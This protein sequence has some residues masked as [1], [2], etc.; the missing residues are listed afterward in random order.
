MRFC[1]Q[2]PKTA[3]HFRALL[4]AKFSET[5][6]GRVRFLSLQRD[7]DQLMKKITLPATS[8]RHWRNF[9]SF[10]GLQARFMLTYIDL[11]LNHKR[12]N[13][14]L[15]KQPRLYLPMLDGK[16]VYYPP[17]QGVPEHEFRNLVETSGLNAK[18]V[19]PCATY[20]NPDHVWHEVQSWSQHFVVARFDRELSEKGKAGRIRAALSGIVDAGRKGKFLEVRDGATSS[21][22]C[23]A[24]VA[25]QRETCKGLF[26]LNRGCGWGHTS[27][28]ESTWVHLKN[29]SPSTLRFRWW[30]INDRILEVN[31]SRN[32]PLLLSSKA[33]TYGVKKNGLQQRF[34]KENRSLTNQQL[35]LYHN[36]GEI[37]ADLCV[38]NVSVPELRWD[39]DSYV[40]RPICE[41]GLGAKFADE[42]GP[43]SWSGQEVKIL[44]TAIEEHAANPTIQGRYGDRNKWLAY[45][46]LG[47]SPKEVRAAVKFIDF[48]IRKNPL[49]IQRLLSMDDEES[50]KL[51]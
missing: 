45:E 19:V 33:V 31:L 30:L 13:K 16:T 24:C 23:Q 28:T 3:V 27:Q 48:K 40:L 44:L 20:L 43:G 49:W 42:E 10:W 14:S 15:L 21:E 6:E 41:G 50:V 11:P 46:R 18:F 37:A 4:D 51:C 22:A 47:K 17:V 26:N 25:R 35:Q 32:N 12:F 29:C 34:A 7:V 39:L 8:S 36:C 9:L 38:Y 1:R 2:Y 5:A